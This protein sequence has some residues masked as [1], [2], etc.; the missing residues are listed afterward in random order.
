MRCWILSLRVRLVGS[1][2]VFEL[3]FCLGGLNV[4][5]SYSV[6]QSEAF[7]KGFWDGDLVEIHLGVVGSDV[8][9][10]YVEELADCMR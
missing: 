4:Y 10:D 7:V 6:S 2:V 8:L 5:L 3:V 1:F 9:W